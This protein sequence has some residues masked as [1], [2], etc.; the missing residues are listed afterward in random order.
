MEYIC[1]S[2]VSV[3]E[4]FRQLCSVLGVEP[5]GGKP[6]KFRAIQEQILYLYKDK[7]QPLLLAIH[8]ALHQRVTVHYNFS[9]FSDLKVAQYVLHKIACAGGT[10]SI[11]EQA[12]LSAVRSHSQRSPRLA[13]HLMTNA[14]TLGGQMKKMMID[15]EVILAS[16][17]CRIFG[18]I[19]NLQTALRSQ[20]DKGWKNNSPF[21]SPAICRP[22]V[23]H[24]LF[25]V[26][27]LE[28]K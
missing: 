9:G 6:G 25:I 14:L 8:E 5:R 12:A 7:K 24:L 19:M 15:T 10:A 16:V 22:T 20:W 13:D 23:F 3:M 18:R 4:F 1:L 21:V 17:K 11:I 2:T 28:S 26:L 27:P